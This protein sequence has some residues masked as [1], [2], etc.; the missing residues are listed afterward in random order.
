M[1][2][3]DDQSILL[4]SYAWML[5]PEPKDPRQLKSMTGTGGWHFT[6]LG[7]YLLRS[8]DG[9]RHWEGPILPPVLPDEPERFPGIRL[10]AY[11]R[12]AMVQSRRDGTIYWAVARS[13]PD[14]F[15]HTWID[16][17]TSAD[18]GTTWRHSGT[19]ASAAKVAFN[20][21][22]LYETPRGDLVGFVR[23]GTPDGV[24]VRSS[25][26]GRTW[27][28]KELGLVGHPFHA[29]RLHDGHVLLVYGHRVT[30]F[31]V[32]ARVMDIECNDWA[33]PELVLRDDGGNRDLGYPWACVVSD[34][35]ALVVYYFNKD[36]GTRSIEGTWLDVG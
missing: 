22:S 5:L 9:G 29:A 16:L 36:D 30:P 31:G 12:G 25:D 23:T 35:R 26:R 4:G 21:T 34:R 2:E 1:V 24:I 15:Q 10:P 32:R 3:L 19:I 6:F 17:L 20:E 18:R 14:D 28:W 11:N 8:S 13:K 7:G 33:G 27:Q